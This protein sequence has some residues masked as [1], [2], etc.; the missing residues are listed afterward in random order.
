[1]LLDLQLPLMDGFQSAVYIRK[2]LK[3]NIPIIALTAG[4]HSN[5]QARCQEIGIDHYIKKPLQPAELLNDL[6]H[7]LVK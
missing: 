6:N 2:K 7:F 4:F 3:S 5:A 1:M